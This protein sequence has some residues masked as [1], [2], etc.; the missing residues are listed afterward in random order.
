MNVV[1]A[2]EMTSTADFQRVIGHYKGDS[3]GAT[4][5]AIGGMHGNEPSGV[6]ALQAVFE[7]LEKEKPKFKGEFLALA[8]N[9]RALRERK[10]FISHDLN[11]MWLLRPD[12]Q[13]LGKIPE[14]YEQTEM[15]ALQ[16]IIDKTIAAR[17][18][19]V[20]FMDLHTTSAESPPFLLIGDTLRNRRFVSN[21]K[22]PV[23]LGLEEQLNGPLLSF[24]NT[25]G[26]ISFG[27]EAGQHDAPV[28]VE[29]HASLIWLI[30]ERAGCIRKADL[31]DY[32]AN[33]NWLASQTDDDLKGFFEVR[34]RYGIH[35]GEE[36]EMRP[37]YH[38]FQEIEEDETLA[39]NE[40]GRIPARE[41]GRIFM[42]KYQAQGDDGFFIV[43]KI[44]P[45][46]LKVS[47]VLRKAR[48]Y[49]ILP[50]LPGIRRHP[51]HP[52]SLIINVRIIRWFGPQVLHLLGY[53]RRSRIGK[54]LHFI[55]RRYDLRGPA[56]IDDFPR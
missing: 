23:I 4:V 15:N 38:N 50:F 46:W 1:L 53:R 11:R 55:K 13:G 25:Q 45:F 40:R 24:L 31:P 20:V 19:P 47:S 37:G 17:K 29:N 48:I 41:S 21:L 8:G 3:P 16:K 54:R 43:R 30:L 6:Q 39:N 12:M 32:D 26:H 44:A 42:P 2:P 22:L 28:S 36:F 34:H 18:G 56:P 9:L 14:G 35:E 51:E 10:R 49:K 33:L 27:F 7:R 5:V 52:G